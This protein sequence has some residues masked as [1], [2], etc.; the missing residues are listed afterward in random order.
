MFAIPGAM[1]PDDT[2]KALNFVKNI[3]DEFDVGE[4]GVQVG[5]VP[6]DC[7][8]VAGFALNE[9]KSK[10]PL[11]KAIEASMIGG[12]KTAQMLKNMR[13]NGFNA[14]NGGR[15]NVKRFGIVVV[16]DDECNLTEVAKEAAKARSVHNIEL[17]VIGV[18][19]DVDQ[20]ALRAIASGPS[21]QHIFTV[22]NYNEIENIA[23]G[24][25]KNICATL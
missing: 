12:S 18:G 1:N 11:I 8:P 25:K 15:E 7:D 3:I 10:G 9:F 24:L 5:L 4:N 20:D 21:D 2:N 14:M 6:K 19:K 13:L 16:D 23:K 22:G 17:F